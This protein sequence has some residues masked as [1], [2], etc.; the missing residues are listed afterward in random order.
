[1]IPTAQIMPG[2]I[3]SLDAA[4]I[5]GHYN[6]TKDLHQKAICRRE[7]EIDR[8]PYILVLEVWQAIMDRFSI[9]Y[10]TSEYEYLSMPDPPGTTRIDI[11]RQKLTGTQ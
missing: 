9:P 7:S 2:E 11:I 6:T 8:I 3:N 10:D 1:M 5:L 4:W